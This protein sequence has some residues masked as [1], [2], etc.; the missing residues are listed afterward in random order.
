[1]AANQQTLKL[2]ESFYQFVKER[3]SL[4]FWQAL[5]AWRVSEGPIET[6]FIL[7]SSLPPGVFDISIPTKIEDTYYREGK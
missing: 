1:M 4:R 5:A 6:P 7:F 2:L 3:P